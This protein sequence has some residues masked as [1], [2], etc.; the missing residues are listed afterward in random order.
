MRL[1]QLGSMIL[2]AA[3]VLA[4]EGAMAEMFGAGA[5]QFAID[6]VTISGSTTYLSPCAIWPETLHHLCGHG[7]NHGG[8]VPQSQDLARR[9]SQVAYSE[10]ASAHA[11]KIGKE[12]HCDAKR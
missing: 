4:A 7:G 1:H 11:S 8:S 12:R 5:N 10:Q 2:A 9:T 6:F 3:V